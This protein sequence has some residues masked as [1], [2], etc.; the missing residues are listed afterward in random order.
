MK[1][2]VME[3][4][5]VLFYGASVRDALLRYFTKFDIR[6]DVIESVTAKDQWENVLDLDVPVSD[7]QNITF[8][9]GES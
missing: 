6:R 1:V 2:N 7:G 9:L 5:I 8:S 3:K 4:E